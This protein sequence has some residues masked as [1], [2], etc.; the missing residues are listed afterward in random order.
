MCIL[1]FR[2]I[3]TGYIE[4]KSYQNYISFYK[5]KLFK[6]NE[7]KK[8]H[9]IETVP[10]SNRQNIESEIDTHDWSLTWVHIYMTGHLPGYTYTWLV[11]YLGT[12]IDDWSLTWVHIYMTGHLPG[13]TYTWLVT[14]LGT[15]IHDWSLTWVHI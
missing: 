1:L 10:K 6:W 9:A 14:Y 3:V 12:H 11:T 13:Y 4:S 15:H 8:Y 2:I 7:K 5:R